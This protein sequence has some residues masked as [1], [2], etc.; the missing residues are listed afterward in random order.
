MKTADF[1]ASC[2]RG[3]V[4]SGRSCGNVFFTD[5]GNKSGVVYD[6]GYHYPLLVQ[7]GDRWILNDRGY[8]MTTG[9][10]IGWASRHADYCMHIEAGRISITELLEQA[11]QQVEELSVEIA[12]L[13]PR[14]WKQKEIKTGRLAELNKTYQFLRGVTGEVAHA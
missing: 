3:E 13:S 11:R 2:T 4:Q 9:K 6:Y 10:H 1:I 5:Q 7:V 14:A 12:T 8:S